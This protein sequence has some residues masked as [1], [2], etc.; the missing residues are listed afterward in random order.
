MFQLG[1]IAPVLKRNNIRLVG[2]GVEE[3][4]SKDFI[5][6]KFFDGG[7]YLKYL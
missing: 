1:D 3:V 5:D 2:I 7:T 6:G 4:G